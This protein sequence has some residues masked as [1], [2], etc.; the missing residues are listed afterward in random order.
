MSDLTIH[1][2]LDASG[3]KSGAKEAKRSVESLAKVDVGELKKKLDGLRETFSQLRSIASSLLNNVG[4]NLASNAVGFL[5]D[6]LV[7]GGKA[8]LDY[9]ERMEQTNIGFETLMGGI[10]QATAHIKELQKFATDTPF[11]FESLA[12]MSQRL[13]SV[14]VKAK[15]V[16]PLMRDIGN[17]TAATGEISA[18]RVEGIT[19]AISQMI[20]KTKVSAEEMEQLAERGVPAWQILAEATGKSQAELRTLSEQGKISASVMV[21]ALQKISKEKFGDAMDKQSKTFGGAMSTI[22][23]IAMQTAADLFKPIFEETSKFTVKFGESL[24]RE[25]TKALSV[26]QRFGFALGEAI[27]DGMKR[28]REKGSGGGLGVPIPNAVGGGVT[29]LLAELAGSAIV[30]YS[31]GSN[32]SKSI[33]DLRKMDDTVNK[34]SSDV[35]KMPKIEL[36][37]AD[38]EK[39]A[40]VLKDTIDDLTSRIAFFGQTS[41]T[42]AVKQKLINQGIYDFESGLGKTAIGLAA[43]LDRLK[44]LQEQQEKFNK[45]LKEIDDYSDKVFDNLFPPQTELEKFDKFLQDAETNFKGISKYA[46]NTRE[47]IRG[48]VELK[49]FLD[50]LER[51]GSLIDDLSTKITD[52][53]FENIKISPIQNEFFSLAKSLNLAKTEVLE[54]FKGT[55]TS[56][57]FN[58]TELVFTQKVEEF[59]SAVQNLKAVGAG[60]MNELIE[61]SDGFATRFQ[62]ARKTMVDFLMTLKTFDKEGKETP[63]FSQRFLAEAFANGLVL[64]SEKVNQ[65]ELKTGLKTLDE[66]LSNL[67]LSFKTLGG[68]S[69]GAKNKI[70]EIQEFL[71]KPEITKAIE[72]R[73][74]S[75]GITAEEL[76][77]LFIVSQQKL[78]FESIEKDLQSQLSDAQRNGKNLSVYDETI[79]KIQEYEKEFGKLDD[80]KR[81]DILTTAEQIDA[82]KQYKDLLNDTTDYIEDKLH[83]IKDEGFKGL[84]KSLLKD[85]EDFL[86]KATAKILASKFLQFIQGKFNIGGSSGGFGG[87]LNTI[88]GGGGSGG[89]GTPGFNP[90]SSGGGQSGWFQQL[91]NLA[92][93]GSRNPLTVSG[94]GGTTHGDAAGPGGSSKFGLKDGMALGS[95]AAQIIGGFIGGRVGNTISMAG[96][97][98]GMGMAIGS[99]IPGLG[100]VVG[101]L[102]GAGAGA[103]FG[104]LMGDPK[105]KRD[106]KEKIPQ[107]NQVFADALKQLQDLGA[108]KNALYSNPEG[109][110]EKAMA[111]RAQIAAGGGI[112][113]ESK[114]YQKESQKMILAKLLEADAI[115]A[116][117]NKLKDKATRARDVDSRLQTSF[118]T[119]VYMSPEFASQYKDFKRQ[120]GMLKGQWTGKDTIPSMLAM[121]EMVLNPMQIARVIQNAGRDVF[122]TAGIPGY[123]TGTYIAPSPSPSAASS[124]SIQSP[125]PTSNAQNFI[126]EKLTVV[127]EGEGLTEAKVKDVFIDGLKKPDV[128]VKVVEA[129]DKGKLRSK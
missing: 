73:A 107:L 44:N 102:I 15:D 97:G 125:T 31:V 128:Q 114:H 80:A 12:K 105:R 19:T 9:S 69:V 4:A 25:E 32:T 41:E 47:S 48:W 82:Y 85:L 27:A 1:V 59:T 50:N 75:L 74:K 104:W 116:E 13:Q 98:M 55:G 3:V 100:T 72:E 18:E 10:S 43:T 110:L 24:Q 17:V 35:Y 8:V 71:A 92:F 121:G 106:K 117:L 94:T 22:K 58:T 7:Q 14:N 5:T 21:Q 39:K 66:Y 40:K 6:K 54:L 129:Y 57:G 28:G 79:K 91:T 96:T 124:S 115:I 86:I 38:E 78:G 95:I 33:A 60:A 93:G 52:L 30:G 20:G 126:I 65:N 67:G 11:E 56:F 36:G 23:D 34:I 77:K 84:F 122:K 101:G 68:E 16:I 42:S 99:I 119:G 46:E 64:V 51:G 37:S 2:N 49:S 61:T 83:I 120:N 70:Q 109:V 53:S 113:F 90:N 108:D 29:G 111:L 62:L 112:Q 123:A 26:A 87:I 127:I 45:T 88:F 89:F 63:L 81:R 118:A 103:L 76:K